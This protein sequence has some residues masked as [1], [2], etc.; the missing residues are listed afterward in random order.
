MQRA[1]ATQNPRARSALY[2]DAQARVAAAQLQ[3]ITYPQTTRLGLARLGVAYLFISHE[4]GVI[5]QMSDDVLVMQQGK[6]VESGTA[7]QVFGVPRTDF[8]R[9]LLQAA[10]NR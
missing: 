8:T 5:R 9:Q 3:I 7:D 10:S 4:V 1:L 6:V 2:H